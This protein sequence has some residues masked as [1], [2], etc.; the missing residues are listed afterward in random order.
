M[1]D[2]DILSR[3]STTCIKGVLATLV[4]IG[5]LQGKHFNSAEFLGLHFMPWDIYVYHFSFSCPDTDL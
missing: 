2:R 4:V 3:D 1:T 5:H